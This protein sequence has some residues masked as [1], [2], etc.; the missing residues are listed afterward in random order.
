MRQLGYQGYIF[1]FEPNKKDYNYLCELLKKDLKWKGLNIA[2][3]NKNSIGKMNITHMSN[4][5]SFL[6]PINVPINYI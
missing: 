5:S 4:L 1:S 3:G 2:L 6:E